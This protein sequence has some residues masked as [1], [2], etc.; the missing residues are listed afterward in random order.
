MKFRPI[1]R[2]L[3]GAKITDRIMASY[4]VED[5]TKDKMQ[6]G[7]EKGLSVNHYLIKMIN[8]ILIAVDQN[9]ATEKK[10]VILSMLDWEGAFENQ[11]H[12]LGVQSFINNYIRPSLVP[13]LISFFQ[14]RKLTVKLQSIWS[15]LIEVK[16]GGPQGGSAGI[17]EYISLTKRNLNTVPEDQGFKFVDD[18][19][20]LCRTVELV[21]N[22]PCLH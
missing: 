18:A 12:V 2:L 4:I 19:S 3:N 13:T 21:V 11:S 9:S 14:N 20:I 8:K 22:R 15:Q 5:M 6:Y 16:G 10:A 7:N 17:L 1:L